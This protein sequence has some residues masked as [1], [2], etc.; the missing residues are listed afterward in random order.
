MHS[1]HQWSLGIGDPTILGWVTVIAYLVSAVLCIWAARCCPLRNS[2]EA[3]AE[4][5]PRLFWWVLALI[6]ILLGINKQLDLQT[7]LDQYGRDKAI[8]YGWYRSRELIKFGF[9]TGLAVFG[10]LLTG[11]TAYLLKN[12]NWTVKLAVLGSVLLFCFV[13]LRASSFQDFHAFYGIHIGGVWFNAT[14][15]LGS[16]GII[17]TAA[18]ASI[19]SR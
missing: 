18:I 12:V 11:L 16:L 14:L 15:E 5:N 9:I 17:F 6:L 10:V 3:K 19:R 4:R 7:W 2:V 8:E 1:H 13:L